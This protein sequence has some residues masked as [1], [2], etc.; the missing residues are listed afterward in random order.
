MKSAALPGHP[1]DH[2]NLTAVQLIQD[3]LFL[4]PSREVPP[5]LQ[6]R[7]KAPGRLARE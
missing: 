4:L 2:Q 7:L 3:V 1:A 6:H 5:L